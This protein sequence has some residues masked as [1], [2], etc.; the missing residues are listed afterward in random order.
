MPS[1]VCSEGFGV[2]IAGIDE[3]DTAGSCALDTPAVAVGALACCCSDGGNPIADLNS[4]PPLIVLVVEYVVVELTATELVAGCGVADGTE[5]ASGSVAETS[6]RSSFAGGCVI[7]LGAPARDRFV[8]E[9]VVFPAEAE[10]F[11]SA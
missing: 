5:A 1:S 3:T 9:L 11:C 10:R 4:L 2:L 8:A 6:R 7:K